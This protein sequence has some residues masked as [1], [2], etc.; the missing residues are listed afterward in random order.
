[1]VQGTTSPWSLKNWV[2]PSFWPTRVLK[3]WGAG[4]AV[5][6]AVASVLVS[7]VMS[8]SRSLLYDLG[9]DAGA[10]GMAAFADG[11][12]QALLHGDRVDQRDHHLDVVARHHHLDAGRHLAG[13]GHVGGPEVELRAV[14]LEERR[15]P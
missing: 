12:A 4:A 8:L 7:S 5:A 1:M 9:D 2:M 6:A 10:H 14:A 11:E 13:P 15:V 3:V